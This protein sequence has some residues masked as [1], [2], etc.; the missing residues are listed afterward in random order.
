MVNPWSTHGQPMVNPPAL[1]WCSGFRSTWP[2]DHGRNHG[3]KWSTM[4]NP[5]LKWSFYSLEGNSIDR[6]IWYYV[7]ILLSYYYVILYWWYCPQMANWLGVACGSINIEAI[8]I[9]H[10]GHEWF[11]AWMKNRPSRLSHG[12]HDGSTEPSQ[13]GRKAPEEL[14]NCM[15]LYSLYSIESHGLGSQWVPKHV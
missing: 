4:V 5:R 6:I 7:I 2:G 11:T 15:G 3:Y 10:I 1:P 13:R 12:H 9:E 8:L 14:R